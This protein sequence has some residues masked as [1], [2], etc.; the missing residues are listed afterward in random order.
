MGALPGGQRR[1]RVNPKLQ[2]I[3]NER[4]FAAGAPNPELPQPDR[5]R[6][7]RPDRSSCGGARSRSRATCAA[8]HRRGDLVPAVQRAGRRFRLRRAVIPWSARR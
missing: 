8:V 5:L 6:H 3:V 4:V 7:V 2:R 1:P